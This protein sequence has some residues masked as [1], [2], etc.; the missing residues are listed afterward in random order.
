MLAWMGH[1]SFSKWQVP[2]L[3]IQ[4]MSMQKEPES[5]GKFTTVSTRWT[6]QKVSQVQ[7][8]GLPHEMYM[9]CNAIFDG[10]VAFW[11]PAVMF[12]PQQTM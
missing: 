7:Q 9:N 10:G 2:G 8:S 11:W 5:Q 4:K 3:Q 6:F 12:F 1:G